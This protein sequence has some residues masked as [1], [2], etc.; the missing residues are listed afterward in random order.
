MT[1]P[2]RQVYSARRFRIVA[3]LLTLVFLPI[4][5]GAS[6]LIYEYL[7][8]SIMVEQ[9]LRGERGSAPARVYAR[10]LVLRP[11]I[12]LDDAGLLKVLNGLR[13]AERTGPAS[14]PGQFARVPGGI[15]LFPRPVDGVASEALEV[16]FATDKAGMTRVKEIRGVASK[17]RHAE[18][19]LEPEL[20]TYLFD[21]D[22]EKRR[23]RVEYRGAAGAPRAGGPR[24]RGSPLLQPPR[25][26]PDP[27]VARSSGTSGRTGRSRTGPARSPSSSARTSS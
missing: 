15:S 2:A 16:S 9:R 10:P 7:R 26:R 12:V 5:I 23:R 1:D 19:A 3:L 4:V 22:R 14:E 6:L 24:D 25:P 13:Y 8:F 18:Q 20:V 21:E 27:P 17:K 11:G